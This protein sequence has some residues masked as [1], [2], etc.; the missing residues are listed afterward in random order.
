M[1]RRRGS[2]RPALAPRLLDPALRPRNPMEWIHCL[3]GG[4]IES[5]KPPDGLPEQGFLWL[6]LSR[7]EEGSGTG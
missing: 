6:D 5:V 2:A 3:P 7:D 1:A 4:Q